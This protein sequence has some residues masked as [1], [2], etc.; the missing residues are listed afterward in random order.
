MNN[1]NEK[2]TATLIHLSVLT[3]YFIPFGNFILPIIIWSSKKNES[4]FIDYNGKQTLNFQL[5]LFI[6]TVILCLIAI[7]IFIYSILKNVPFANFHNC[8]DYFTE[9]FSIGNITGIAILGVVAVVIF[10]FLKI[11]EFILVIH[12][13][14]KTSNGENYKYPLSITFFK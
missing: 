2:L 5:S 4:E 8:E 1:A 12:A 14:V 3:Q 9:N 11:I 10:F 6:Y 7:P 13:A